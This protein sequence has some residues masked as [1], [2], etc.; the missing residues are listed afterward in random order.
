MLKWAGQIHRL[1]EIQ[2]E[3]N[4]P[5]ESIMTVVSLESI[6]TFTGYPRVSGYASNFMSFVQD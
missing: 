4:H 1:G 3:V 6:G 2:I 5:N